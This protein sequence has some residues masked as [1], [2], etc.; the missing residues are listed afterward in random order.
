MQA[1]IYHK[2]ISDLVTRQMHTFHVAP[3]RTIQ[4]K[5]IQNIATFIEIDVNTQYPSKN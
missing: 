2:L 5:N 3:R 1:S 4:T